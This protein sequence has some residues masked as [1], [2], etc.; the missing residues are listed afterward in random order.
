MTRP[1]TEK[2]QQLWGTVL[3]IVGIDREPRDVGDLQVSNKGIRA[4]AHLVAQD[5]KDGRLV[6]CDSDGRLIVIA[7]DML[8][9]AVKISAAGRVGVVL[10]DP[11]TDA[12]VQVVNGDGNA[13]VI[14]RDGESSVAVG[15]EA[16]ALDTDPALSVRNSALVKLAAV[17]ADVWDDGNHALRTIE[18]T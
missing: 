4:L 2:L 10:H 6:L 13:C 17:L 12:H 3:N 9:S 18:A 14:I 11:V 16:D 5:G 8:A 15:E 1:F 7:G